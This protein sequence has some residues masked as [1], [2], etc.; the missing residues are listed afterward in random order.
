[1]LLEENVEHGAVL[2]NRP[3]KPVSNAVHA[4]IHLIEMPP[5]VPTGL[6]VAQVFGEE[7]SELDAPLAKGLM[8]HLDTALVKQF[9]HVSVNQGK[10]VVELLWACWM[11]ALGNGGGKA[12]RRSRRV[13]LPQPS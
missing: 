8:T 3:P 2:V 13:S 12:W 4:R 10:A 9:L 11:M 1:M 7:G 5:R 6:S